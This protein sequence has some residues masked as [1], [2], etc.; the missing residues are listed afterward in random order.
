MEAHPP[1]PACAWD[2]CLLS[3]VLLETSIMIRGTLAFAILE[4]E[5]GSAAGGETSAEVEVAPASAGKLSMETCVSMGS[6]EWKR[7]N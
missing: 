7:E 3:L 6:G 4:Q 2:T 1:T 5:M